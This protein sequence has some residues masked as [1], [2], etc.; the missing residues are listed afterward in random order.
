LAGFEQSAEVN[1]KNEREIIM[2]LTTSRFFLLIKSI[3]ADEIDDSVITNRSDSGSNEKSIFY[4]AT[5]KALMRE[6][7]G[8][9]LIN[10]NPFD[11]A[12]EHAPS[13]FFLS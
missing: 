13:Y 8:V 3:F 6:Y 5:K 12:N 4:N 7:E 10:R 11:L 9:E 1:V 2:T